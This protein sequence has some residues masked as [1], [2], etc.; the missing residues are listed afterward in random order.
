[1][2]LPLYKEAIK[3][4]GEGEDRNQGLYFEKFVNTWDFQNSSTIDKRMF[5]EKFLGVNSP[6]R[7]LR[8]YRERRHRLARKLGGE[9]FESK[10]LWRLVSGLGA[11][12]PTEAGFVWH[13]TLGVPYLPGS[14]L[15][16]ALRAWLTHWKQGEADRI[17]ELFGDADTSGQGRLTVFDALPVEPSALA[18]DVMNPH[19]APYYGKIDDP[20]VLQTSPPADYY[21]PIP[22]F[23]LTVAAGQSFEFALAPTPGLGTSEDVEAGVNLLKEAVTMIGVG[24]KTA[25]G[26]GVFEELN[27]KTKS[28]FDRID[29]AE[30]AEE[31]ERLG[32]LRPFERYCCLLES[33]LKGDLASRKKELKDNSVKL[34]QELANSNDSEKMKAALL[35]R[36]VWQRTGDWEGKM[37]EKQREK[38]A[39]LKEI[40]LKENF[41]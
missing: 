15:K 28:I 27:E 24:A 36:D 20:N 18:L 38:V 10:T 39:Q 41:K 12:H 5:L 13:R 6:E 29:A 17:N 40:L 19:Y 3:F 33:G 16:G 34:Y 21:A 30:K 9:I 7:L 26:Y 4:S 23:F 22:V 14:S 31:R 25:V 2:E 35:L 8:D 11:A 1:M 37:S 32:K